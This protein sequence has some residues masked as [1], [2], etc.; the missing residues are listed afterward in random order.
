[1]DRIVKNARGPIALGAAAIRELLRPSLKVGGAVA[2]AI[3][4]GGIAFKPADIPPV[5]RTV[6]IRAKVLAARGIVARICVDRELARLAGDDI[7]N[8]TADIAV[9]GAEAPGQDLHFGQIRLAKRRIRTV[10]AVV[11]HAHAVHRVQ[12]FFFTRAANGQPPS[13]SV[14]ADLRGKR[15]AQPRARRGFAHFRRLHNRLGVGDFQFDG[16]ALGHNRDLAQFNGRFR[17]GKIHR[18]G[19]VHTHHH[20]RFAHRVI[21]HEGRLHFVHAGQHLNDEIFAID[22]GS[23][24][25]PRACDHHIGARQGFACVGIGDGPR[26]FTR[27][28]LC[29]GS[30][31]QPKPQGNGE[32]SI[33]PSLKPIHKTPP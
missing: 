20:I 10:V 7:D 27:G 29:I 13:V 3:L 26:D 17:Q 12:Q 19:A 32:Q 24:A 2:V 11:F 8:A 14:H 31:R 15:V 21:A 23:R 25:E 4:R 30:M 16:R 9:L 1:M 6:H 22:I 33:K 5:V 28:G 18:R